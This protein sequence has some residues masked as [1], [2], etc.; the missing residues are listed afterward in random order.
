[1][2]LIRDELNAIEGREQQKD[3]VSGQKELISEQKQF[4]AKASEENKK[5]LAAI[6][7]LEEPHW[8]QTP[9]FWIAAAGLAVSVAILVVSVLGWLHP[10]E[11]KPQT[12]ISEPV[13]KVANSPP[14]ESKSQPASPAQQQTSPPAI[15]GK[16]STN[17]M[18]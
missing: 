9:T 2:N 4:Q 7:K 17:Q 11:K 15:Y 3:L 6:Q 1:V 10:V 14:L 18:K 13:S 16:P 12:P 8:T 5:L